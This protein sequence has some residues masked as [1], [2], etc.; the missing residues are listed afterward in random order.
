[1]KN[2]IIIGLFV[3]LFVMSNVL[4]SE[5]RHT[6]IKYANGTTKIDGKTPIP[7]KDT[8]PEENTYTFIFNF[9]DFVDRIPENQ[10]IKNA[11]FWLYRYDEPTVC[12]HLYNQSGTIGSFW[13]DKLM[14]QI[15]IIYPTK[16]CLEYNREDDITILRSFLDITYVDERD[17]LALRR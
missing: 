9:T 10:I 2:K 6:V 15:T 7:I 5:I 13:V 8:I 12:R 14:K 1:M 16:E 17:Y 11:T 4:G 3:F